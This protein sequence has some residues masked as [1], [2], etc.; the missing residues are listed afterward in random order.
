LFGPGIWN[1]TLFIS[2]ALLAI[3]FPVVLPAQDATEPDA[4]E[5]A[6]AA[7]T[8]FPHSNTAR[9]WISG[10]FNTIVQGHGQF[11]APYSGPNSLLPTPEIHDSRVFTLYTG[12]LVTK[13]AEV[14]LDVESTGGRGPSH[15]AGLLGLTNADTVRNPALGPSPYLSRFMIRQVL[16]LSATTVKKERGILSLAQ[17]VPI[18]RLEFRVGKF[19]LVDFFDIN[20]VGSDSHLQFMNL[21]LVNNAAYDYAG[22]ARGYTYGVL[23]EFYDRGWTVRFAEALMPTAPAGVQ[24]DWNL[25]RSKEENVEIELHPTPF[26]QN[27]TTVRLLSFISHANRG[28]YRDAIDA[29]LSG[30]TPTP[31]VETTRKQGRQKYGFGANLEQIINARMRAFARFSWVSSRYESYEV[32]QSASIGADYSGYRWHRADDKVGAAFVTSGISKD[33]QTYL[34]L[35]GRGLLLGDGNLNY[36]REDIMEGYYTA[37]IWRG[38]Y[39]SADVQYVT[40]PGYNVDRGPLWVPSLRVHIEF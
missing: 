23:A 33:V 16:P 31:V 15:S 21:A 1:S 6:T 12:L 28:D 7:T 3:L 32:N 4:H 39:A 40:H 36:G 2:T 8:M 29:F 14:F 20:E 17:E 24:F 18:R 5:T 34:K 19:S 27:G 37:H 26:R 11:E 13:T 38:L 9:W 25:R 10:Q 35:G 22:D 30:T